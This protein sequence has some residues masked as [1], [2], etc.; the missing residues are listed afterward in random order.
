M[1]YLKQINGFFD[2]IW[3]DPISPNAQTLYFHLLN[4]NNR[5]GWRREFTTANSVLC[6]LSGLSLSGLERARK[7]LAQKDYIRYK[8]GTGNQ[9]GTYSVRQL[10]GQ[11]DGQ[12]DG[13]T[14]SNP[15]TLYK[16]NNNK[17]KPNYYGGN[18]SNKNSSKNAQEKD[19][20]SYDLSA[21]ERLGVLAD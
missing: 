21:M 7:E 1:N 14:K 3:G 13:Q 4:V 16:Q 11:T 5:C 10:D 2:S 19:T 18:N 20:P 6:G 17:T 12:S 15:T 8:K 9:A